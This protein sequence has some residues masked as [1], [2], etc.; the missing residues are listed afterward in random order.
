[1]A[2]KVPRYRPLGSRHD[3]ESYVDEARRLANLDHPGVVPVYDVG[4]TPGGSCYVVSKLI[5]GQDLQRRT[6]DSAL[7]YFE[8]AILLARIAEALHYAHS[9]GLVHRDIKPANILIDGDQ[10]PYL[11]DFG[12]ARKEED[13]PAMAS[14]VGTPAYMSPE[15]A[16]GEGHLI[17]RRTDIFS[18]GTV[19]FELL[20][21]QLPFRGDSSEHILKA[22]QSAAVT[23]PTVLCHNVPRELERI[24]LKCLA[25]RSSDRYASA[26]LLHDDLMAFLHAYREADR[27]PGTTDAESVS[28]HVLP[29]GLRSFDE[30]DA[31]FFLRLLPGPYDRQGLPEQVRVLE[32]THRVT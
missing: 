7:G 25:R 2:I 12:L 28:C 10:Q 11:A 5:D 1:M 16:H 9:R 21:G 27:A 22:I 32:N 8:T 6:Q 19:M 24:C 30:Q 20:T 3:L 17:D 14:I 13:L 26:E 4:T 31:G 15:Q 29:K 23:P 18:L